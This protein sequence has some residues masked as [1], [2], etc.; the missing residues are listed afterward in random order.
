MVLSNLQVSRRQGGPSRA[1]CARYPPKGA[2]SV[3]ELN[4][5]GWSADSRL[6]G[7]GVGG[8]LSATRMPGWNYRLRCHNV[9]DVGWFRPNLKRL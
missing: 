2:P 8:I 4:L 5:A 9:E 6:R 3:A 7:E 1:G